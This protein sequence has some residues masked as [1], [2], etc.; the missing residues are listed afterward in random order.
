MTDP[1]LSTAYALSGPDDCRRL[2]ADWASTY[3]A[4]FAAGMDYLLPAHVA[5]AFVRAGGVGPV[6]DVGAGTG[7]LGA[8]LRGAGFAGVI[9]GI[10]LVTQM[11]T[12][13]RGLNIYR[14]LTAGD[15]TRPLTLPGP[16]GGLVSSGTFTRGHVGPQALPHLLAVAAPGAIFAISVNAAVWD[17]LGF[18]RALTGLAITALDTH[19]APIY[20]PAATTRNPDHAEDRALIVTFRKC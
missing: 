5:A 14:D 19:L 20:G 9:D 12:R 16:Y 2:Y 11:L 4:D 18:A 17:K 6:L 10:D 13:A 3:D 7:L 8:A 1:D 15:V